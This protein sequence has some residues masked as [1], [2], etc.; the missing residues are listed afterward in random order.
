[1]RYF[2]DSAIL[3]LYSMLAFFYVP[4][5]LPT[6]RNPGFHGDSGSLPLHK[7]YQE[8]GSLAGKHNRMVPTPL[9]CTFLSPGKDL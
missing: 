6:E 9:D 2:T 8:K 3:L 1:M 7:T 5:A 4:A